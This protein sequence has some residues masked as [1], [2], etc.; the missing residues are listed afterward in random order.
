[1]YINYGLIHKQIIYNIKSKKDNSIGHAVLQVM[2][3]EGPKCMQASVLRIG[4]P[5]RSIAK[6][7]KTHPTFCHLSQQN[8]Y[9][10]KDK[11]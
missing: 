11:S 10:K 3:E 4:A 8:V 9:L 2:I 6:Y 5:S 1:M 7:R